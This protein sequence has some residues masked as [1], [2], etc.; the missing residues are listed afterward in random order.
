MFDLLDRIQADL[1]AGNSCEPAGSGHD[2]HRHG[3]GPAQ[4]GR[5]KVGARPNRLETQLSR[6]KD[7]E[8]NVKDLLSKTEDA[9]MAKTM[10]DFSMHADPSTSPPCR[11]GARVLQPSLLD[12]L[13]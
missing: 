5:A 12:F 3:D 6:L 4:S 2:R 7:A 1:T 8:L 13:R 11:S 9:D 10:V